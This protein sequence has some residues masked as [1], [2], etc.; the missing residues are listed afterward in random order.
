MLWKEYGYTYFGYDSSA[1]N[2]FFYHLDHCKEINLPILTDEK[3]PYKD[4][5]IMVDIIS[6]HGFWYKNKNLI[7]KGNK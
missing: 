2:A 7:Y 5:S 4:D 6:S 3:F 1:T